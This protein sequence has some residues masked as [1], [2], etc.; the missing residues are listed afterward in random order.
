MTALPYR[1]AP[2]KIIAFPTWRRELEDGIAAAAQSAAREKARLIEIAER[3]CAKPES[4]PKHE[5]LALV[6][7]AH[8]P[9]AICDPFINMGGEA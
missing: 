7:D 2:G 5:F 8:G 1:V 4:V 3:W 9:A 6:F